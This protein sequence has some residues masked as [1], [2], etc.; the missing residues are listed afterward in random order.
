[1]STQNKKSKW[2]IVALVV[3]VLAAI[4]ALAQGRFKPDPPHT[5]PTTIDIPT[6]SDDPIVRI[7]NPEYKSLIEKYVGFIDSDIVSLGLSCESI[8]KENKDNDTLQVYKFA[9]KDDKVV[10]WSIMYYTY[11]G[12]LSDEAADTFEENMR[13]TINSKYGPLGFAKIT[14]NRLPEYFSITIHMTG[15]DDMSNVRKLDDIG[16]T[17]ESVDSFISAKKSVDSLVKQGYIAKYE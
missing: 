15:L 9:H 2:G 16:L 8:A 7:L 13:S 11:I 12:D 4:G 3:C 10:E 6:L 1:M 17:D 14:F 5:E